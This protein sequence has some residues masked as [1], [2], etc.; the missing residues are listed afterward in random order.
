MSDGFTPWQRREVL[1]SAQRVSKTPHGRTRGAS[2]NRT[3]PTS[4]LLAVLTSN[5]EYDASADPSTWKASF[6]YYAPTNAYDDSSPYEVVST[7]D[8][9]LYC[10]PWNFNDRERL[11]A[12]KRVIVE[13]IAGRWHVDGAI[14][15]PEPY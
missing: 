10:W 6:E 14:A 7:G 1:N 11:V 15:C 8:V 4:G 2:T 13:W 9:V 5:M 12:G 3:P